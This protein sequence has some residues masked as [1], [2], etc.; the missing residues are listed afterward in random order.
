MLKTKLISHIDPESFERSVNDFIKDKYVVDMYYQSFVI[1]TEWK[2]SVP[3]K[4]EIVNRVLIAYEDSYQEEKKEEPSK[5]VKY[6]RW[7]F[8]YDHEHLT[9]SIRC[10]ICG[11]TLDF[12]KLGRILPSHC[13]CCLA[14]TK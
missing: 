14:I 4:G 2:G 9:Q 1:H 6:T 8:F 7:A 12:I 11:H 13:P 5:D 10:E 3:V